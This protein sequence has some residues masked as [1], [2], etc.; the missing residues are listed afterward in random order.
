MAEFRLETERLTLRDWRDDDLPALSALCTDPQVM[1]TI[2]PLHDLDK[3]RGLL[4]RLQE[5]SRRDGSTFWAMERRADGRVLGFCGVGLGTVPFLADELEI[6]W[7][8]AS[9]C[10]G[11]SYAREA[12]EATLGWIAA[13]RPGRPVWAITWAGNTRSRGLMERL[14]MRHLEEMDFEHPNVEEHRLRPH[15]TYRLEAIR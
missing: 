13:N 15:V 1:K 9:D 10:W 8:L 3:T 14:G 12:A 2:G 7:R 6:G 5:R 4:G 11:Q